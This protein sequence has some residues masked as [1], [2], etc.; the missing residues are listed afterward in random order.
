M[1]LNSPVKGKSSI[2]IF[3]FSQGK[4][5]YDEALP[6]VSVSLHTW[7]V[8]KVSYAGV[9]ADLV[10]R[11]GAA[12]GALGTHCDAAISNSSSKGLKVSPRSA[13]GQHIYIQKIFQNKKNP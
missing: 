9:V 8:K 2:Y 1:S 12:V 6:G 13:H 7:M 11:P 10:E 3:Q 5:K 4:Y